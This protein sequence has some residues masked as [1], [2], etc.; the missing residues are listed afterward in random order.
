MS[1]PVRESIMLSG[2]NLTFQIPIWCASFKLDGDR[3]R[4]GS[5]WR[6]RQLDGGDDA[7]R[8]LI[9]SGVNRLRDLNALGAAVGADHEAEAHGATPITGGAALVLGDL[10][11]HGSRIRGSHFTFS[12]HNVLA[13]LNWF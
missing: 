3:R 10:F 9:K 11:L 7:A 12:T 5:A 13:E 4:K 6:G 1:A 8:G 2:H